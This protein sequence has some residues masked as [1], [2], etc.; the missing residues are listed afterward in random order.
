LSLGQGNGPFPRTP[1]HAS[2]QERKGRQGLHRETEIL[3]SCDCGPLGDLGALCVR[4]RHASRQERKGRQGLHRETEILKSCDCGPLGDLGAL[5]V[6][7]RHAS[8]QER[9]GRQGRPRHC[10][11]ALGVKKRVLRALLWRRASSDLHER[12]LM[13]SV[14]P[15]ERTTICVRRSRIGIAVGDKLRRYRGLPGSTNESFTPS[16]P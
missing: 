8:R 12:A 2:R 9:K 3:K 11:V 15:R 1:R 10:S 13:R 14:L 7:N 5:C 16:F 6:R 4:N